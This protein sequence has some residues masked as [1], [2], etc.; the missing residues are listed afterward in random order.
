MGDSCRIGEV[1]QSVGPAPDLDRGGS[2]VQ[3]WRE[4]HV[5]IQNV[6]VGDDR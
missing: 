5:R 1:V 3:A 4:A 6:Y 2:G